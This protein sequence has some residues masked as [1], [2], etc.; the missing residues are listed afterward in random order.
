MF[1]TTHESLICKI[2]FWVTLVVFS[3]VQYT[4]SNYN[5]NKKLFGLVLRMGAFNQR[6]FVTTNWFKKKTIIN[7]KAIQFFVHFV[8]WQK[9]IPI[10]HTHVIHM[11]SPILLFCFC[12]F[13]PQKYAT[14]ENIFAH[15]TTTE[16]I[17]DQN[18]T[19]NIA[20]NTILPSKYISKATQEK[21]PLKEKAL[22]KPYYAVTRFILSK[23]FGFHLSTIIEIELYRN[24]SV[25]H[26]YMN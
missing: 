19:N 7:T 2:F 23:W 10:L 26:D 6:T 8:I 21:S 24:G 25:D 18:F 16:R 15:N 9:S 22:S 13:F 20:R 3:S 11:K 12:W 5:V 14:F 4:R 17:R 1:F